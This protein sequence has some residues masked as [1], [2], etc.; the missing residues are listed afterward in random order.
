M[1]HF[2]LNLIISVDVFV[3]RYCLM[4]VIGLWRSRWSALDWLCHCTSGWQ[5]KNK[6]RWIEA[7]A[8]KVETQN[9]RASHQVISSIFSWIFALHLYSV[10]DDGL[11]NWSWTNWRNGRIVC[12][13]LCSP[14]TIIHNTV[15]FQNNDSL[16][17]IWMLLW[18]WEG[19]FAVHCNVVLRILNERNTNLLE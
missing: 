15:G 9:A 16:M 11:P 1:L 12:V 6:K 18:G 19:L 10:I 7:K 2:A 8:P 14:E 4:V 13:W 3:A 17:W 5:R